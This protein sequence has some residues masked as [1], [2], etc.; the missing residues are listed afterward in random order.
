MNKKKIYVLV[1]LYIAFIALGLPDQ[2]LG[3]AWPT[4]RMDFNKP[5]DAAGIAAFIVTILT[6]L[7]GYLNGYIAIKFSISKILTVSVLM[8]AA[9]LLGYA[10]SPSWIIFLLFSVPLGLG[11]GSIDSAL[12]NYVAINYSSRHMSWLHAFWGIGS[13]MGP[14]IMTGAFAVGLNW[15][16]GYGI[17]A[18][19]L[20]ILTV[21]FAFSSKLWQNSPA[22]KP[23]EISSQK[24][25]MITLNTFLSAS[26][27]FCYT[28]V[29][30]GI[31]LWI[32]SVMTEARNFDA[33]TAG[34]LVAA[35]WGSLTAGR[36]IVGFITKIF[37]NNQIILFSLFI[38][39]FSMIILCFTGK[40][41]TCFSL[42]SLGL[43]LSGLYP[44]SMNETHKRYD[45]TTA[46][47]LMG[48]QVGAASLG[49]AIVT[50]ALGFIIQR[51]GLN[52]LPVILIGLLLYLI[53]IELRLRKLSRISDL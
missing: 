6:S 39:L 18:A 37:S 11:A 20:F 33:L 3:I 38:S 53:I 25:K 50:P 9:G 29:E 52:S 2:L 24:V 12:N 35:Y 48:H 7:S 14:L 27:F 32:Y 22:N 10:L 4:I 5:L 51:I 21:I 26:F 44:C 34:T 43:A 41:S 23:R 42:I 31:G 1:L 13:T 49:F 28:S 36:I 45:I 15:R 17:V 40:I 19:I 16:G 30:G 46:Q 47:I 8:T